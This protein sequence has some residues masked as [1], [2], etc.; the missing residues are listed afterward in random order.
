VGKLPIPVTLGVIIVTITV[1]ILWS[2][3]SHPSSP[4]GEDE[5]NR[6]RRP[7]DAGVGTR[8]TDRP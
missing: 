1:S 2:L 5:A 8:T 4:I 6:P 3:I 7:P